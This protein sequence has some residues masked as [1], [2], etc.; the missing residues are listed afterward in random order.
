MA[1]R[2]GLTIDVGELGE[3][4]P[5]TEPSSVVADDGEETLLGRMS[6]SP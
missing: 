4:A 5:G 3:A 6:V 1:A 2:A